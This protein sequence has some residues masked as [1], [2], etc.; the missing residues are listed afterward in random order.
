LID[1]RITDAGWQIVLQKDFDSAKPITAYNR[2]AIEEY[3]TDTGPAD[4]ALAVNGCILGVVEAK[5]LTLGPQNVLLQ[6]DRYSKGVNATR[7]AVICVVFA[8]NQP[9]EPAEVFSEVS[10]GGDG[11]P[12]PLLL[13]TD[14][15]IDAD[16]ACAPRAR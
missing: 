13:G 5:K 14:S 8:R 11:L 7:D 1:R 16:H 10:L 2:C 6:A 4:Y 15:E 9:V 3:P 12:F